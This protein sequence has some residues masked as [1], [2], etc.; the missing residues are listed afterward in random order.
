MLCVT[1]SFGIAKIKYRIIEQ[2]YFIFEKN[3]YIDA[4]I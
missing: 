1:I 3:L 2:S 4:I